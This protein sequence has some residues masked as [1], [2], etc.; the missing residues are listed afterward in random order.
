MIRIKG[1]TIH[2]ITRNTA[3]Y[4]S[5]ISNLLYFYTRNHGNAKIRNACRTRLRQRVHLD[6][7]RYQIPI[8]NALYN[9]DI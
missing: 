8:E 4:K 7:M 1:H 3:D 5:L 6:L 2:R 9:H